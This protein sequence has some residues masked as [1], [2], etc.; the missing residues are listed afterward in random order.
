MIPTED[1]ERSTSVI[2]A[3]VREMFDKLLAEMVVQKGLDFIKNDDKHRIEEQIQ[4]TEIPAPPFEEKV[5]AEDFKRRF[6]V[7]GLSDVH[8]DAEGNTIGLLK[9]SAGGPK[10]V[11]SAHLDTVFPEGYDAKVTIDDRGILHA[12]G[13]SDDA[14]GLAALLSI[15]RTFKESGIQTVGDI[16]FVGTVGEEGRGDL[17][18]GKYLFKA[19][20]DIDGFISID[21]DGSEKITY[22]GL[23]SKRFELTFKGPGGHSFMA[24]GDVPNPIHAMGRAIN[25]IANI[26][27]PDQPKTT[28]SVSVVGGGTSVNS[29][30]AEAVMLTDTRSVCPEQ[31]DR[32]V[33][34][35][36]NYAKMSVIEEN[37]AL[38][39]PW[40]SDNNIRLEIEKI[41]DRPSGV[42]HPDALHVQVAWAATEAIG[43]NPRLEQP[44]STDSSI[45]IS[46]GVPA[47]TLGAGGIGK[48]IHSPQETF[49]PTDAYLAVQRVFL[50]ILALA[51]ITGTTPPLLPK[52]SG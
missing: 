44:G 1:H 30:A 32:T 3:D 38:K 6:T 31:L 2:S 46:L 45:P 24:F 26:A 17:R 23:G 10:L 52:K 22:L 51:G 25:K 37:G 50:T 12:P 40:D 21:G 33:S 18:G 11:V 47:L 41:G 27:V 39:I 13:I 8:L 42:C 29:I 43:G 28:F 7:L 9:G 16:L 35:L 4:I 19:I 15:V 14:A 48:G 5:R 20:K 36:V 34:E 49:D